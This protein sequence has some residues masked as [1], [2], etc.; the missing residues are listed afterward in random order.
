MQ[1]QPQLL[2]IVF[3]LYPSRGFA[4]LLNS[5]EQQCDQ[6]RNNG[7]DDQQF[8]QGKPSSAT[9]HLGNPT[10]KKPKFALKIDSQAIR[11]TL[12]LSLNSIV[13]SWEV[14]FKSW[15]AEISRLRIRELFVACQSLLPP[16]QGRAESRFA[17]GPSPKGTTVNS[18]AA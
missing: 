10:Q 4:R 11:L 5:R 8:N 15:L 17:L 3:A 6:N 12:R 1:C 9:L 13:G 16:T 2:E 7:N 18:Q 14:D